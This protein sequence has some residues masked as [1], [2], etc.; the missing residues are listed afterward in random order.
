[1]NKKE[2]EKHK[3]EFKGALQFFVAELKSYVSSEEKTDNGQLKVLSIYTRIF[4]RFHLT[5][6]LFL[7]Y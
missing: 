5:Q 4:I 3:K 7:K 1:M 6:R 2:K